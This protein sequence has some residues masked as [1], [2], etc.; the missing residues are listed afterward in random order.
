HHLVPFFGKAHIAYLPNQMIVGI[1]KLARLVDV[2]ARRLQVQERMTEQ[3]VDAV[4]RVLRPHGVIALVEAEHTCMCARGIRKPGS[5]TVTLAARGD[6]RHNP[7]LRREFL[8]LVGH[9]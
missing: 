6:Y 9:A 8:Q 3:M 5:R 1:S 7:E 4:E 2:L